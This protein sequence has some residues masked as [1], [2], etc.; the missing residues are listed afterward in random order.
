MLRLLGF[1][2]HLLTAAQEGGPGLG[3]GQAPGR[4]VQQ[5]QAQVRSRDAKVAELTRRLAL[6]GKPPSP[7]KAFT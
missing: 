5:A 2:D 4:A 1:G 6:L 3:Q 7:M